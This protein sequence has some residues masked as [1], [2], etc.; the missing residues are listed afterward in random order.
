MKLQEFAKKW[1]IS[2]QKAAKMCP[3]ISGARKCPCCGAWEVPNNAVAIYIPDKRKY[4]SKIKKYRYVMDAIEQGM[5]IHETLSLV[6]ESEC[7]TIV[8][9]LKSQKLLILKQ[10]CSEDNLD[11]K[12]YML[13]FPDDYQDK[14]NVGNKGLLIEILKTIQETARV[15]VLFGSKF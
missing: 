8:A 1:N 10:G 2:K 15:A 13:V 11:Y 9:W 5:E 4:K 12:N 3:Y 14:A 7:K 6:S